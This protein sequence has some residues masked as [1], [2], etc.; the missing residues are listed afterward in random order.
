MVRKKS[1]NQQYYASYYHK[2]PKSNLFLCII[3][4]ATTDNCMKWYI[5]ML[6]VF[7]PSFEVVKEGRIF[8]T[9]IFPDL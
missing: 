1:K 2:K 5:G 6:K 9:G 4:I 7:R 8:Q 3:T